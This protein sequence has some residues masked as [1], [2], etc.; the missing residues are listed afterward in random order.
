[1]TYWIAVAP[2]L[3]YAFESW[4]TYIEALD[5]Y[6]NAVSDKSSKLI[7]SLAIGHY[8]WGSIVLDFTLNC[9]LPR[10]AP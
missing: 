1:M 10:Q 7:L 5:K 2:A 8:Y 6:I 4:I 9:K 3:L